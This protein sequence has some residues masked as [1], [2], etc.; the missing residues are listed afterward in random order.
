MEL[1]LSCTS[2]YYSILALLRLIA[3]STARNSRKSS[4]RLL[5]LPVGELDR[6]L[7]RLLLDLSPV[8]DASSSNLRVESPESRARL[9][10]SSFELEL[11]TLLAL[12]ELELGMS[13][14]LELEL[15]RLVLLDEL[16]G[17][18]AGGDGRDLDCLLGSELE[19]LLDEDDLCKL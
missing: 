17:G 11:D 5:V 9:R 6:E 3:F 19:G 2:I 16:G 10:G 14:F 12:D 7:V 15:E 4:S 8:F 18:G 13:L 1:I